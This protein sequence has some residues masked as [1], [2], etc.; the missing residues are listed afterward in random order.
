MDLSSKVTMTVP[1]N[2][3]IILCTAGGGGYGP[4]SERDPEAVLRDVVLGN[5]SIEQALKEY[6]VII[7]EKT[8]TILET[9]RY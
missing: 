5:I 8:L 7:D 3:T 4:P 1:K 6:G 2:S 9:D